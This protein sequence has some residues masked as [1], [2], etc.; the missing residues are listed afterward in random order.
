MKNPEDISFYLTGKDI[1]NIDDTSAI[2]KKNI[3]IPVKYKT[4]DYYDE[5]FD[6]DFD[7]DFFS[8]EGTK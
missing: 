5:D 6:D 4:L 1:F 8:E 3:K 7:E 2:K